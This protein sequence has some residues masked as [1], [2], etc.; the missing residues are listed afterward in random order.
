M[1]NVPTNL[2][3]LKSKVDKLDVHKLP[4]VPVDLSKLI[5]VVKN[6]VVKKG[7]YNAKIKNTEDKISDITNTATNAFL[8]AKI[9]E[10][11][12]EISSITNLATNASLN[13]KINEVKGGIPNITNLATAAALTVVENKIPSVSNLVKKIDIT[14]KLVKLKIKLLLTMIMINIIQLKNLTSIN[15][16]A[17]LKQAKLAS[18]ND[19]ANFVKKTVTSNKNEL[20]EPS[21][22]VKAMSTKGLMKDLIS[23]LIL[24]NGAK[25]FSLGIFQNY[26]LYISAKKYIKYFSG[27]TR[28]ELWKSSGM[29]EEKIGN[30]TESNSHSVPTFVDRHVLSDLKILNTDFTLGIF[31]FGS[32][33]LT[34]N[35]DL[36]KYKDS[37]CDIGF[38]CRSEFSLPDGTMGRDFI[39]SGADMSSCVLIDNKRK[40]S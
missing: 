14:Q 28:I 13:D 4:P 5:D 27:T 19:I 8:N 32:V 17:R 12:C 30:I 18:K 39:I 24:L 9:N 10:V 15:F 16:T 2:N 35:A 21:K 34:K 22:K 37:G 31:L 33:K 23:K 26:L 3:N 29:S 6:D 7:V 38:D 11:K 40:I 20:N 36:D 1:K 25:Y